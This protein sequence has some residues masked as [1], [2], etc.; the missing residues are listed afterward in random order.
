MAIRPE[1]PVAW[2]A[3]HP[4]GC[5]TLTSCEI[6]E[7]ESSCSMCSRQCAAFGCDRAQWGQRRRTSPLCQDAVQRRGQQIVLNAHI[8][9]PRDRRR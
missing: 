5:K 8:D 2:H 9:Q 3:S 6:W 1:K 7:Q 4:T